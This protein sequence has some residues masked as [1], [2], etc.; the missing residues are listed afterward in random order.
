M[1][2][3]ILSINGSQATSG[4]LNKAENI[5]STITLKDLKTPSPMSSANSVHHHQ[6]P[7]DEVEASDESNFTIENAVNSSDKVICD[8]QR[9]L[10]TSIPSS[11][12]PNH[13]PLSPAPPSPPSKMETDDYSSVQT[14]PTHKSIHHTATAHYCDMMVDENLENKQQNFVVNEEDDVW[15]P[16]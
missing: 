13:V 2:K 6:Q 1:Y 3:K 11:S 12:P 16:W 5:S 7:S 10:A 4:G 15:R 8:E 14:Y 9:P